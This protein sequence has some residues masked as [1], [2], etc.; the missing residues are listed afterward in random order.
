MFEFRAAG[1]AADNIN[2]ESSL[3]SKLE[4]AF[5]YAMAVREP[6]TWLLELKTQ[7]KKAGY[8]VNS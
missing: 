4:F 5:V 7:Y 2:S 6:E 8:D 1:Y 3:E